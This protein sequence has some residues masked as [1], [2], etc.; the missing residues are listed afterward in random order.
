MLYRHTHAW[1]W[2]NKKMKSSK[3]VEDEDEIGEDD[4]CRLNRLFQKNGVFPKK[5]TFVV[6]SQSQLSTRTRESKQACPRTQGGHVTPSCDSNSYPPAWGADRGQQDDPGN[7]ENTPGILRIAPVL[8][9]VSSASAC[10]YGY[11]K[12]W[13]AFHVAQTILV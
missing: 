8:V 6:R 12:P 1:C 13:K 7:S 5:Y 9:R 11:T 3:K 10:A 4:Q 2:L